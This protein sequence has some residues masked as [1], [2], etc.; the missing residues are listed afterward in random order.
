MHTHSN[1]RMPNAINRHLP[2]LAPCVCNVFTLG[3]PQLRIA[4]AK[5]MLRKVRQR[6]RLLLGAVQPLQR[7]S[8][9]HLRP[10]LVH[11]TLC[12]CQQLRCR[13]LGTALDLC[14]E[15]TMLY[16]FLCVYGTP[17]G[18]LLPLFIFRLE[19]RSL[20]IHMLVF[21]YNSSAIITL[22]PH[23]NNNNNNNPPCVAVP[24]PR[25]SPAA[26]CGAPPAACWG[27]SPCTARQT[28]V[29]ATARAVQGPPQATLGTLSFMHACTAHGKPVGSHRG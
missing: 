4:S 20:F 22:A 2:H 1:D 8:W 19:I 10:V 12:H 15:W 11:H 29:P 13:S 5:R 14:S 3:T 7:C 26:P 21:H 23:N 24:P 27:T 18:A 16:S 28:K 9:L 17:L 25:P 6:R